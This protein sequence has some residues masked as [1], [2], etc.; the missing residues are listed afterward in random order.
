M[1]REETW[2]V[3]LVQ[4]NDNSMY[5][6]ITNDL[7]RRLKAHNHGKGAKYTRSRRPVELLGISPK[8]TKSAAL[9]LE[10]RIKKTPAKDKLNTT[11]IE[12][13]KNFCNPD[14]LKHD[15]EIG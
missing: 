1:N 4:C 10:H 15:P 14:F 12:K 7:D 8:M 13:V 11:N 3:Y 6:G 9:R 5:C 2:I